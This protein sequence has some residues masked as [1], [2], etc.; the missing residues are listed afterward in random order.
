MARIVELPNKLLFLIP[1]IGDDHLTHRD[2]AF[3]ARTCKAFN[4]IATSALLSH[5]FS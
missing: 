5:N 3:V 1:A 4:N 2:V